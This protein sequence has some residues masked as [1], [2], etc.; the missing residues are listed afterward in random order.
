MR[1]DSLVECI[2]ELGMEAEH[3]S[4]LEEALTEVSELVTQNELRLVRYFAGC[5]GAVMLHKLHHRIKPCS[6]YAG[7]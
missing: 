7:R 2:Q 4:S 1:V 6:Q 5:P 3:N